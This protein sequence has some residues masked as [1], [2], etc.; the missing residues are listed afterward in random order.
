MIS[1]KLYSFSLA[2]SHVV[3][4]DL[5]KET[6]LYVTEKPFNSCLGNNWVSALIKNWHLREV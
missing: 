2:L 1:K 6:P 4:G 3:N 5:E